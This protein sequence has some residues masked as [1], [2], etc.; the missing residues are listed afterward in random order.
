M[1]KLLNKSLWLL[2]CLAISLPSI[3]QVA[4]TKG[5]KS[6]GADFFAQDSSAEFLPVE[7]A[8]QLAVSVEEN[9]LLLNWTITDGY[10]LYRDRFKFN[11]VDPNSQLQ[12]PTFQT[13]KVK[14]DE[15]FE[16]ELEVYY[17]STMVSL[18]LAPQR[19]RSNSR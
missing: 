19:S 17:H 12:Q 3:G 18:P 7:Q 1:N 6:S 11:A 8:Y 10:Y 4:L 14:W 13:G 15:Y 16:A 5:L 2:T 9:Q